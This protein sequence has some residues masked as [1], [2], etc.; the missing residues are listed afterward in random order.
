MQT[1][2]AQHTNTAAAIRAAYP[3]IPPRPMLYTVEQFASAEPAFTSAALR[4]LIF[5]AAPRYSSKGEIP[6]NGLIECGAIVRR[7]RKVMI[8]RERFLDWTLAG[9][10]AK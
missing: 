3:E 10:A 1:Q 4:N 8:H 5:K 2:T 9:G 6:G 7:G